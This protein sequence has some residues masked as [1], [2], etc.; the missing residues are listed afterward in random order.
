[1][2]LAG[3]YNFNNGNN[4]WHDILVFLF[5][6]LIYVSLIFTYMVVF[7]IEHTILVLCGVAL[8][9]G[10]MMLFVYLREKK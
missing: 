9:D 5:L 7:G 1:M 10:I 6:C 3:F 4:N 8:M 2:K